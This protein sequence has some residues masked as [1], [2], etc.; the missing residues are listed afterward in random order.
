MNFAQK[1]LKYLFLLSFLFITTSIKAFANDPV[2]FV[3]GTVD[4]ASK[5][6][7]SSASIEEKKEKLKS[8][9]KNAVD[10]KGIGFYTLGSHRKNLSSDEK[11]KYSVLFEKYFLKTFSSRL[12][13]YSDPKIEVTGKEK[14]SDNYTIVS[15]KLIATK[16]I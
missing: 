3:Q 13:E 4:N 16:D 10:I 5:I 7:N 11:D 8:I 1:F 6:L 12:A 2:A 15:S 9:A 14:V